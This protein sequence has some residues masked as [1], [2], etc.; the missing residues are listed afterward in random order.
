ILKEIFSV[1]LKEIF[2]VILKEIFRVI[3]KEIFKIFFKEIFRVILKFFLQFTV[4]SVD[5]KIEIKFIKHE[6]SSILDLFKILN[7]IDSSKFGDSG[8]SAKS[9][10]IHRKVLFFINRMKQ[11]IYFNGCIDI[12]LKF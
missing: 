10:D 3:L 7:Q 1:I 8:N 6:L 11:K 9:Q 2:R 12:E 4:K 5:H